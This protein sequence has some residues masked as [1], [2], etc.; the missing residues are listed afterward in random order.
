MID[1]TG[2]RRRYG[3]AS[4]HREAGRPGGR[5]RSNG[6]QGHEAVRGIDFSVGRG[7]LF[8]LLGTNGAGKTSTLELPE[9]LAP[10]TGGRV[11]SPAAGPA[12][13]VVP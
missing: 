9:G 13:G 1:V 4:R 2:L 3:A 7:E 11:R 10:P 8:A 12:G 6:P 5:S